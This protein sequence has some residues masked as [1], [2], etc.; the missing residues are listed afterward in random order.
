MR[1]IG[2]LENEPQAR[3]FADFLYVK[4]I[5]SQLEFQ[6]GEG[7]GIWIRDEDKLE[8]A[9]KLLTGFR[10]SPSDPRYSTEAKGAM[11]LREDEKKGQEA[12]RKRQRSGRHLFK[13]LTGY[14]FGPLTFALIAACVAVFI[15]SRFGTDREPIRALFISEHFEGHREFAAML[16]EVRGGEIWR[17]FTPVLIHMNLMHIVFNMLWLRD[18][19]SMIEGRQGTGHL[20]I[21]VIV[22]AILSDF[23]Q[24]YVIGPRFGGMSGV[25]Y[26]L[27]G[28]IWIRGRF[29]PG[30]GLFL[31]P[32]TVIMMLAWLVLCYTGWLG[33]VANT[34]HAAGLISG[35]CWG[36]LSSL[37]H[38]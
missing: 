5:E 26:G 31:H 9:A 37:R 38:R 34:A 25:V 22:F 8:P 32:T 35:V 13:P 20:A 17:I 29:D 12:Y 18:L 19:G 2:Y 7:W 27:M 30:S 10:E 11:Q 1:L 16:P 23:A 36:Y 6:K 14:G 3:T 21:L 4:G 24:Y 33:P 15:F 28:Y